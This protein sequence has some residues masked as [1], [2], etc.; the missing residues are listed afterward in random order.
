MMK[1]PL[2]FDHI[3]EPELDKMMVCFQA[4]K[5]TFEPGTTIM[6]YSN[7]CQ[8]IGVILSGQAQL[9]KYDYDGYCNI[10]EQLEIN[11]V[12]GELLTRPLIQE[13]FEVIATTK[14]TALFFDYNHLIERC[15]KGCQHHNILVHN[16]LQILSE[17]SQY[18]HMRIDLI[19]RRTLRGKLLSYFQRLS[20]ENQS[21][22]FTLPFPLYSLAD[23]LFVDRSAM[24]REMK[25]LREENIISSRGRNI[26][27]LGEYSQR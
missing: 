11:S 21:A 3:S 1:H 18:L 4:H 22:S 20:I 17:H 6:H 24:L 7:R 5:K 23:F 25:K 9:V 15:P 26:T 16:M 10:I 12:F 27:L 14:T 8:T 13:D 2:I 19:S